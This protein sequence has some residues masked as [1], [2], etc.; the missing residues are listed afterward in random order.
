MRQSCRKLRCGKFREKDDSGVLLS[1]F[2]LLIARAMCRVALCVQRQAAA[3]GVLLSSLRHGI[4]AVEIGERHI[5]P[6]G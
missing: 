6:E 2:L 3:I 5:R 1:I 4:V